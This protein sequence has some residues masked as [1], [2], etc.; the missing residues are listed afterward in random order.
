MSILKKTLLII[1]TTMLLVSMAVIVLAWI[2]IADSNNKVVSSITQRSQEDT[3]KSIVL[4]DENSQRIALELSV[5]DQSINKIILD[6]YNTSFDTLVIALA[7]QIFPMVESFDF[8]T[9]GE[10]SRALLQTNKAI[11]GV[12]LTTEEN[13]TEGAIYVFG[14][15]S[16]VSTG[17]F[18]FANADNM[19][20]TRKEILPI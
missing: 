14:D 18:D 10:V 1:S 5:A 15:F 17:V 11:K 13:P 19:G 2:Y 12:R 3:N 20:M 16:D 4:L 6:L 9:P 7:N 8:E